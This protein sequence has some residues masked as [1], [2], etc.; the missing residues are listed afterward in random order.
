MVGGSEEAALEL[1]LSVYTVSAY[2]RGRRKVAR[3][4]AEK[5]EEMTDGDITRIELVWPNSSQ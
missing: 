3:R 2:R 1:G 4:I 5:I